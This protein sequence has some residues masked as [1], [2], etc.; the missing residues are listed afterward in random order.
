MLPGLPQF[1][2]GKGHRRKSRRGFGVNKTKPGLHLARRQRPQT[3][4]VEQD[5]Q[6]DIAQC[7][8]RRAALRHLVDHH[9]EFALKVEAILDPAAAYPGV[10]G[11]KVVPAALIHQRRL[12]GAGN[13]RQMKGPLHAL[14]MAEEGRSVQPLPGAGQRRQQTPGIIGLCRRVAARIER[15]IARLQRRPDARGQL[16]RLL[17]RRSDI[18]RIGHQRQIVRDHHQAAVAFTVI[19]CCQFHDLP[20]PA[21]RASR[22]RPRRQPADSDVGRRRR[23]ARKGRCPA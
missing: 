11:K 3:D 21:D 22:R 16:Q 20:P 8:L 13:R 23:P 17:E 19:S 15:L 14:A 10:R 4:I 2:R 5:D 9:R 1:I 18:R 12:V 7:L 6:A